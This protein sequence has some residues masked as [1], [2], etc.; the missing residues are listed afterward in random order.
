MLNRI[1]A[2]DY[3]HEIAH[4]DDELFDRETEECQ[5]IAKMIGAAQ[6]NFHAQ[7]KNRKKDFPKLRKN[8]KSPTETLAE[9]SSSTPTQTVFGMLMTNDNGRTGLIFYRGDF[10][11]TFLQ[12]IEKYT[13]MPDSFSSNIMKLHGNLLCNGFF[14]ENPYQREDGIHILDRIQQIINKS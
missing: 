11:E 9:T 1:T 3:D 5:L 2:Q 10:S 13:V 4:G 6:M 8:Q 12:G 7:K 14:F